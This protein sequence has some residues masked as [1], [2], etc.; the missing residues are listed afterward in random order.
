[1]CFRQARGSRAPLTH[2]DRELDTI[3]FNYAGAGAQDA[4][5]VTMPVGQTS[6][7]PCGLLPILK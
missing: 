2:S 7:I 3:L 5:S 1:M 6:T 4:V